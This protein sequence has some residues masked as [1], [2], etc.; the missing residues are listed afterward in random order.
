[1]GVLFRIPLFL[2]GNGNSGGDPWETFFIRCRSPQLGAEVSRAEHRL[3]L[4]FGGHLWYC[5]LRN[6]VHVL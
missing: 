6:D 1:M 4:F 5:L 2:R 3:S